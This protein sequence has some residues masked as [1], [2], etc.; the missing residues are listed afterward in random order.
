MARPDSRPLLASIKCPT[1]VLVGDSDT[2]TPPDLSREIAQGIPGARLAIIP[3]CGHLS[4]IEQP[5]P[6]NAALIDWLRA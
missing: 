5:D 1:L 4:T 6:V 2:L 3:D